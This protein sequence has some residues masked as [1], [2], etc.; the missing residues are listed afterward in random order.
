MLDLPIL[1]LL[2]WLPI[3]GGLGVLIVGDRSGAKQFALGIALLTFLISL[4][5]RILYT[6]YC[7]DAVCGTYSLG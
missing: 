4:P 3:I 1:S 5:V 7:R 2:I 6:Q